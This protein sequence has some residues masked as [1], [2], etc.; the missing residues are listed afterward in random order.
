MR[1]A[2][3]GRWSPGE[4]EE[5]RRAPAKCAE[6]AASLGPL[7]YSGSGAPPAPMLRMGERSQSPAREDFKTSRRPAQRESKRL[8]GA[9]RAPAGRASP[10]RSLSP[11]R[12][13][14]SLRGLQ[15]PSWGGVPRQLRERPG[16]AA[17][18]LTQQRR[19]GSSPAPARW[20]A[21]TH[22]K[23]GETEAQRGPATSPR[24]HCT[25]A[26]SRA[27]GGRWETPRP[28]PRGILTAGLAHELPHLLGGG[29]GS[30]HAARD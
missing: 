20:P 24:S 18:A 9:G 5:G 25:A 4:F 13:L 8:S 1:P 27:G 10:G 6:G 15:S 3:A 21:G 23:E 11:S 7:S 12:R 16:C 22:L 26:S 19:R 14:P 30:A 28:C 2:S 17:A 29:V